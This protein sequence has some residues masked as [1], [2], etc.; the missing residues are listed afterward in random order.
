MAHIFEQYFSQTEATDVQDG[1]AEA[2]I[3]VCIKYGPVVMESPND[4]HARS[5]IMWAGTLA[6]NGLIGLGKE[7][8]WASHGIE[9]EL[10]AIY[11]ITHGAGLAIIIPNWMKNVL[12]S[13]TVSKLAAFGVNVWGIDAGK[14]PMDIAKEAI[15]RTKDFFKSLG[16]PVSLKEVDIPRD[17][18]EEMADKAIKH[19]GQVGAFKKL[20][21]QD[22]I[23]ILNSAL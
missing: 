1:I 22:I 13:K 23:D 10:S 5:N 8:D 11:D 14:D 12:S 19:Y 3:R 17:M 4:Y 15:S 20:N 9:H 7:S 2:L 16:M 18:L 21:K 6:L